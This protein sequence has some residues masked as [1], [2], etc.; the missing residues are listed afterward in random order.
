ML[1]TNSNDSSGADPDSIQLA[2]PLDEYRDVV[3][4]QWI[5]FNGHMNAGYY[6]VAFDDAISPW[7]AFVGLDAEHRSEARVT[8]FSVENHITYER[9]L[10]EATNI[11]VTTQLLA[12]DRKRIHAMQ[13]MYNLDEG[14]LAAT[15]EVMS[16][17]ISEDTRRVTEMHDTILTRL[18]HIWEAHRGLPIPDQ[19]GSLM[20]V[21]G[22]QS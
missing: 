7:M 6:L 18:G 19:V 2:A 13:L 14:H 16:L 21:P 11:G 4:P 3:R 17:H 9:E 5:D 12:Y 1:V 20:A 22:W 15:N 8:T 10:R